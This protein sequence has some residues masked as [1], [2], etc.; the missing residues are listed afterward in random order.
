MRAVQWFDERV[1]ASILS[2][3]RSIVK[4]LLCSGGSAALLGLTTWL[5]NRTLYAVENKQEALLSS[6][7]LAVIGVYSV[8]YFLTRGQ[9]FYLSRAAN[10][11]TADLRQQLFAKLQRL[12]VSYFNEK[13]AGA[14]Q[15]VLTN[16]VSVYQSA[17][18]SVRDAIDGPIK[19]VAGLAGI[20]IIQPVLSLSSLAVVPFMV[21][22]IQR[23]ARK[24]RGAQAQ[25]QSDLSDLSAV[26]QEQLQG[27]RIVKAFAA[28]QTVSQR[29]DQLVE[30]S[31]ESQMN[32]ARRI[33]SLKPMVEL[34]GAVALAVTV[35][36]CGQLVSR[37]QLT[38]HQLGSFIYALDVINQ[39]FKSV[40]SLKQTMAQVRAAADRIHGEILDVPETMADKDGAVSLETVEG[41]VEFRNVSFAY[42]DGTRALDN[43][44]F[45]IEP[46]TSL[47]LVG[48]SGAG[49]STIAD[50]LLRF[51]DP[52]EGT[53]LFDG[54]DVR[55]LQ[56]QWYR[57]QF[58]VVP[59]Q[60]FLFAGTVAD[61][62]R[63]GAPDATEEQVRSATRQAHVDAFLDATPNGLETVLGER[64]V[65]LSG[66]EGQRLAIARA[67][68][69]DPKVLLLDEAT[70]N[71]DSVS[72]KA[73]TEA[74]T[75]VMHTRTA[76][77]IAHRLSTAARA[78][79]ILVLRKGQVVESG[80]H[81]ELMAGGGLYAS[82]VNAFAAGGFD[83]NVG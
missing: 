81:A 29:Y 55:T 47:A 69:R 35:F 24:M 51:Y 5:I 41:R 58:G 57:S 26:T 6:M 13:R 74:L 28:E 70:S 11:L 76:L 63:L 10:R 78:D 4:G 59:Q 37:N 25:V 38:V 73:V 3:R 34:I 16:D 80:T 62:L 2:Q 77:F 44:S 33:A 8:R 56:T 17:V 15:S 46:G 23:N 79:K 32:A 64:G 12:P 61:N 21:Y 83:D 42:P 18:T 52:T 75:E 43:V 68:V 50:L 36:V 71:L 1:W 39:G 60:T 30:R 45:T 65:R 54:H 53:V 20:V 9:M 7:A 31:Y 67:L 72:E 48:P 22:F 19:I 49:K 14:I 27:A 82:M 66:G 40:G